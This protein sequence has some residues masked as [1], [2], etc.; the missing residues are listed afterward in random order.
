M[1]TGHVLRCY[2]HDAQI[3]IRVLVLVLVLVITTTTTILCCILTFFL[4]FTPF[5]QNKAHPSITHTSPRAFCFWFRS[6]I[7]GLS[8]NQFNNLRFKQTQ[9]IN[10]YSAAHVCTYLVS[11]EIVTCSWLKW[12]LDHPM[13]IS[14]MLCPGPPAKGCPR[15]WC[16]RIGWCSPCARGILFVSG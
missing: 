5:A 14:Q 3:I 1:Q 11:S 8:D 7:I 2:N 10:D 9:H 6:D 15:R 4:H 16:R 13:K 12:L